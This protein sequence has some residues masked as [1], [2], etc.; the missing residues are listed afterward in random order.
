MRRRDVITLAAGA[1]TL[2]LAG[3]VAARAQQR[4]RL[5]RVGI[6]LAASPTDTGSPSYARVDAFKR[7]LAGLG[8]A[9]GRNVRFEERWADNDADLPARAAEL[10]RLA[11]D[12]IFVHGSP[13]L[14]AMRRA[15]GDI[16]VVFAAVADPVEQGFVS[17]LAHPGGNITGFAI[18]EFGLVTK[19]LDFLKKLVPSIDRVEFLYDP[20]QPAAAGTGNEI[21]AAAL[22]L[23]LRPLK[24][25]VRSREDI[26]VAIAALAREPNGSLMVVVSPV[27]DFHREL[28]AMLAHRH[29]VPTMYPFRYFVDSGGLASYGPDDGDMIRRAA[30]YVDRILKGEKPPDLPVQLPTKFE[31]VLNLKTA[32]AMGLD[33]PANVLAL[34][35]A[36]IE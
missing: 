21:E 7:G 22:S 17:S 26:E 2:P 24:K 20:S 10:A 16:P 12:A 6:L 9:E 8:W 4:D 14:R 5:R 1:A 28:I 3:P 34:A 30:G 13:A 35:D 11:P 23:A 32:K 15:S 25:P 19:A 31:L 36:V 18:G 29:R 33:I 27:T